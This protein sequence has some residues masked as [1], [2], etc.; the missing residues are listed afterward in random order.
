ML[1]RG[2]MVNGRFEVIRRIGAGQHGEVY[3][4]TSIA[5]E[6]TVALKFQEGRTFENDEEFASIGQPIADEAA[7]LQK[8]QH[9]V[10]V[11]RFFEPGSIEGRQFFAMEFIPG[12]NLVDYCA[13][14][15]PLLSPF[16]ASIAGQLCEILG[17]IHAAG[18]VHCDVKPANIMIRPDGRL[19]VIDV[20]IAAELD[21]SAMPCGSHGWAAPEQY[22]EGRLTAATDIYALG[23]LLFHL[24]TLQRPFAHR[25]GRPGGAPFPSGLSAAMPKQLQKAAFAMIELDPTKRP[26]NT[27][28][29]FDLLW[30]LIPRPGTPQHPKAPEPDPSVPFRLRTPAV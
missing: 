29:A 15:R 16:A 2:T 20:S 10:G 24:C 27:G 7:T 17:E 25:A 19:C 30:P 5:H 9:V 14:K 21:S 22:E 26:S 18:L 28:E 23:C 1:T 3:Q 8:L 13:D 12:Q 6:R 4:A 11:P